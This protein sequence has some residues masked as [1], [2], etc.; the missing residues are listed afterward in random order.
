M[1]RRA[2]LKTATG[3]MAL[4]MLG[5]WQ[6]LGA[7]APR[8][9]LV[10]LHL[11]GGNDGLNTVIP[12]GDDEY[13]RSRPALAIQGTAAL[14]L[15]SGLALHPALLPLRELWDRGKMAIVNGA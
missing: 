14:S 2:F 8:T 1:H 9:T 6:A 13:R 5:D 15:G 10:A 11:F 7:P 4:S 12:I 3:L